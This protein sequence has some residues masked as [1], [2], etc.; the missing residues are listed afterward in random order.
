MAVEIRVPRLGWSMEEGGFVGWLRKD[1]DEIQAGEPLYTLEGDKATQEVEASDSGI[2]RIPPDAPQP[3]STVVVGALLGYLV[4]PN[5]SPPAAP[6][7]GGHPP[8]LQPQPSSAA[9]ASGHPTPDTRTLRAPS[10]GPSSPARS[11]TPEP[12]LAHSPASPASVVAG[13]EPVGR[14]AISPRALRFA[15]ELGV[16]WTRLNG[17]GRSGRIR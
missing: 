8:Q 3:G 16:D 11:V 1:G 13:P 9:P 5:E 6:G 15:V 10:V 7:P 17:T 2:L 14:I 4:A 12:V